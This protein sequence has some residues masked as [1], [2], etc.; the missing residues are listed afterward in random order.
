MVANRKANEKY[1]AEM[2]TFFTMER[3]ATSAEKDSSSP[4]R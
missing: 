1:E 4:C 3:L 2:F